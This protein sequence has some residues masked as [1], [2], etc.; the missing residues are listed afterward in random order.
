MIKQIYGVIGANYGDE[1]KGRVTD[2]LCR[3]QKGTKIVVLTNGGA[4]RGHTVIENDKRHVFHHFGAGTFADADSYFS[5]D[6]IVNPLLFE[7]EREDLLKLKPSLP[8]IYINR[9]CRVT[10]PFDMMVNQIIE[11]SRTERHG[12]CGCGIWET[13]CRYETDLDF[14]IGNIWFLDYIAQ[15]EY[16]Q[17]VA[18]YCN[19]RIIKLLKEE[20][21]SYEIYNDYKD[22]FQNNNLID[23]FIH[24]IYYFKNNTVLVDDSSFLGNYSTV[25]FENG[26]GL[27]LDS[28]AN[29]KLST[30]SSTGSESI[31]KVLDD[32]FQVAENI[33]INL[34][35]I[36]RTYITRHGSNNFPE[37]CKK[38]E[39]NEN[40]VEET[41]KTNDF[42]GEFFYGKLNYQ[43]LYK[44]VINDT[45][46]IHKNINFG[47][48][49][50]HINDYS[51]NDK[52]MPIGT[53]WMELD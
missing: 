51:W 1:G 36:T 52:N 38:E 16:L 43:E 21:L 3:K 39:I 14:T 48:A 45:K 20:N 49:V 19:E 11:L 23:N 44:R 10:T 46:N 24:S 7:S 22:L 25:V 2:I 30:P 29:K 37:I 41:N 31:Q 33:P 40:M 9:H 26:Q 12:S 13:I 27:M 6:F 35:Y 47:L 42:Q 4:Q 17:K 18:Q 5:R 34:Y 15:K 8:K 28:K 53:L 50:T 32:N